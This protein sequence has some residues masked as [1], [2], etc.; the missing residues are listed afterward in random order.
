MP[1]GPALG[2][3]RRRASMSW[4]A[5]GTEIAH[6]PVPEMVTNVEFGG[7]ELSDLYITATT[8]L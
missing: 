5:G 1:M 2:R 8:S 7:P 3:G 4:D 6:V